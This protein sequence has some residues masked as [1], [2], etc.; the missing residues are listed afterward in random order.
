MSLN[1]FGTTWTNTAVSYPVTPTEHIYSNRRVLPSEIG[2]FKAQTLGWQKAS[3]SLTLSCISC[4]SFPKTGPLL[5]LARTLFL[6]DKCCD[7]KCVDRRWNSLR[8]RLSTPS[9][10]LEE[11]SSYAWRCCYLKDWMFCTY[12]LMN[13]LVRVL[14]TPKIGCC[15]FFF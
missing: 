13:K 12:R 4:C 9:Q 6:P 11:L 5:R 15:F 1:R 2:L 14:Q 10:L 7:R 8:K 3:I